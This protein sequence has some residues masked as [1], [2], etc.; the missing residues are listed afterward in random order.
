MVVWM[1]GVALQHG[2]YAMPARLTL[3]ASRRIALLLQPGLYL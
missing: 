3:A 1:Q 2:I